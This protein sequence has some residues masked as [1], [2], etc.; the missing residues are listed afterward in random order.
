MFAYY[1]TQKYPCLTTNDGSCAQQLGITC[2]KITVRH[3]GNR[4]THK[5][6]L[7]KRGSTVYGY[8]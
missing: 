7:D 1:F 3:S 5:R 4:D 2:L 6:E 8:S